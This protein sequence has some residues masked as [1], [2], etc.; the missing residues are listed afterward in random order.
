MIVWICDMILMGC[1]M[2]MW[3][4]FPLICLV[5]LVFF[6]YFIYTAIELI[7][8]IGNSSKESNDTTG[9]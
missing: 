2:A 6:A 7:I 4:M 3:A 1:D 8:E 9:S 5:I